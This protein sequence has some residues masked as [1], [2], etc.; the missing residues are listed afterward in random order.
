MKLVSISIR[1]VAPL[2]ATLAIAACDSGGRSNL[3]ETVSQSSLERAPGPAVAQFAYVAN[4]GSN[5]VSAY[6]INATSGALTPV[7]GSPFGAGT[8]AYDV[9]IDP[10]GKFAY[11][12]NYGSN[13]VSAYT[14]NATSGALT[15][16]TGSPFGAG[17]QS[18]GIAVDP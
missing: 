15:P 11:V 7:T 4:Y 1:L 10:D 9:A 8:Q 5:D 17:I 13:N 18:L 2:F 6:T 14:I 3:P 16:V 12:T